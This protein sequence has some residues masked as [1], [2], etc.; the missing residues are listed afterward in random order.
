MY[1]AGWSL[2]I[3]IIPLV[4][5]KIGR[6]W[7]FFVCTA[8]T[9]VAMGVM[10][11]SKDIVVTISMMFLA[12]ACNSGRV[13]VA[14]IY[15]SEFFTPKWQVV[16]GTFFNFFDCSTGL[17]IT[18]YF[19]FIDKHYLY[20]SSVGF[21]M[22]CASIVLTLVFMVESPLWQLKMGKTEPGLATMRKMMA[23]NGVECE[24]EIT[25]L[26]QEIDTAGVAIGFSG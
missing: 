7:I 8:L 2:T 19:D 25:A 20:I 14:F 11:L 9:A 15:A 1:F 10:Y 16:F 6:K 3:L 12:G 21:V 5:D 13:M 24:D 26:G 4:A 17:I 23:M 22:T 18:L